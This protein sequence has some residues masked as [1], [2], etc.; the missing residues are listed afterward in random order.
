MA[1]LRHAGGMGDEDIW[2]G[3]GHSIM[4]NSIIMVV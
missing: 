3:A 1:E 2:E 4:N